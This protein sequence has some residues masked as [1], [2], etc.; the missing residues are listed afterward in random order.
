MDMENFRNI[1]FNVFSK[2]RHEASLR[3]EN[4]Y[5]S[6]KRERRLGSLSRMLFIDF[7]GKSMYGI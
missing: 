6:F 3:I 4:V 2:R 5:A 1:T 7:K